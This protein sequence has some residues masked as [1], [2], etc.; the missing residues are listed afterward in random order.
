ML[1]VSII[2][3]RFHITRVLQ[4][5]STWYD[6]LYFQI[7]VTIGTSCRKFN[8][9]MCKVHACNT[10]LAKLINMQFFFCD[11]RVACY[12]HYL[13]TQIIIKYTTVTIQHCALCTVWY[14]KHLSV[15]DSHSQNMAECITTLSSSTAIGSMRVSWFLSLPCNLQV[16]LSLNSTSKNKCALFTTKTNGSYALVKIQ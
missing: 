16:F 9:C 7:V 11:S 3:S 8:E 10:T 5:N 14:A 4:S 12:I 1:S 6:G 15:C 2:I 13:T